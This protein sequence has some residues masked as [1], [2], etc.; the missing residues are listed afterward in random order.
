MDVVQ[1]V[2]KTRDE[3]LVMLLSGA[4]ALADN[5]R[6]TKHELARLELFCRERANNMAEQLRD[7]VLEEGVIL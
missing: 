7:R 6:M 5:T 1:D 2:M 4:R 3:L